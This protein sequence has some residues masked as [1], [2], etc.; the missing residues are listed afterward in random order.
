MRN[1]ICVMML[2][3]ITFAFSQLNFTAP[4]VKDARIY[5]DGKINFQA[6]VTAG[7]AY[8]SNRDKNAKGSGYKPFKR[9]EAYW[10]NFVDEN[11]LLPSTAELW[12][13][14]LEK[15][16]RPQLRTSSQTMTDQSNWISLGP[17]DFLNRPTSY[18]NLGRVNCITPHGIKQ[19]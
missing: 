10:Q 13:T 18:L 11:G 4:W 9:W 14:W 3:S 7:N 15:N 5:V 1:I 8:W 19:I 6:V 17:T 12:G 16:K 2:T